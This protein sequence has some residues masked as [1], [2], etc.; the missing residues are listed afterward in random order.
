[1]LEEHVRNALLSIKMYSVATNKQWQQWWVSITYQ[2]CNHSTHTWSFM[3]WVLCPCNEFSQKVQFAI[4]TSMISDT[5]H[6]TQHE[7]LLAM[8][9]YRILMGFLLYLEADMRKFTSCYT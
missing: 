3:Q 7:Q 2:L 4:Y 5:K 6:H 8:Q 9:N 1:M